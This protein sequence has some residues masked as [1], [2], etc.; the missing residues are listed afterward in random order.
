M[1]L[2][3]I[4]SPRRRAL[5]GL[6]RMGKC[7]GH[8]GKLLSSLLPVLC[9]T[10]RWTLDLFSDSLW[11]SRPFSVAGAHEPRSFLTPDRSVLFAL[12]GRLA[13]AKNAPPD[14]CPKRRSLPR[15]V[16]SDALSAIR[17]A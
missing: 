14:R 7:A 3:E 16:R 13:G 1:T 6:A 5:R 15:V 9:S 11:C 17:G 12:W 8:V 4:G 2:R 10:P